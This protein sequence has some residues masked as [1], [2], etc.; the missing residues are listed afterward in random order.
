[1]AETVSGSAVALDGKSA[2]DLSLPRDR[3]LFGPGPKRVLTLDGGGVRGVISIAFLE[4]IEELLKQQAGPDTRLSDYFDLIGGTSTGSIIAA[5]LALGMSVK[6]IRDVYRKLAPKVFKSS[7]LRIRY[8]RARFEAAALS[9]QL[10][11]IIG[12]RTLNSPELLTGY[13]VVA[14]RMDTGSVWTMSNNPRAPYWETPADNR[15]LGNRHYRLASLVRASTAAPTYFD[16]ERLPIGDGMTDGLF[17]DGGVS[18]YNNPAISL[19]LQTQLT[20]FKLRWKTGPEN[21]QIVSI[22]TGTFRK[23]MPVESKTVSR[24]KKIIAAIDVRYTMKIAINSLQTV[25]DDAQLQSLMLM[26][27]LGDCP[28]RWWIN[29]EII[30]MPHDNPPHGPL[31]RFFRYDMRLE[32]DWLKEWAGSDCELDELEQ[33]R[34]MENYHMMDRSY[35]IAQKAAAIQVKPEDWIWPERAKPATP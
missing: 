10:N 31:F 9:E 19:L 24:I 26:Q 13:C 14:K 30:D 33:I 22:G 15:F 11:S 5:G 16:P 12:E 4:R 1:M 28:Q 34:E 32:R 29:S 18:P 7:W 8:L 3:H 23:R 21:L 6:E 35:A 17:I 27:W 20:A 25:M 2:V